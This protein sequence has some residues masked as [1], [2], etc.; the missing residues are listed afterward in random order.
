M[1]II[2]INQGYLNG[3]LYINLN[4]YGSFSQQMFVWLLVPY[5]RNSIAI[6]IVYRGHV[7][8]KAIFKPEL[9]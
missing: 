8:M 9:I 4:Q 1:P 3:G 6:I 2:R 7:Y 5:I